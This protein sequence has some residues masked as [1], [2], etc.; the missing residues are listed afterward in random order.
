MLQP[1]TIRLHDTLAATHRHAMI[2]WLYALG[3]VNI[4]KG[5]VASGIAFLAT[6]GLDSWLNTSDNPYIYWP[7]RLII[8]AL[9]LGSSYLL[10][11]H[12][13]VFPLE[14]TQ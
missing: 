13:I 14:Q 12:L 6:R 10:M 8:F 5:L 11:F 1:A 2:F 9:M 7:I 3:F 4:A